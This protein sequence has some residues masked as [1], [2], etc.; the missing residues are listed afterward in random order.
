MH[1]YVR[2]GS[3]YESKRQQGLAHFLEHMLFD[4]ST[5]FKPDELV[6]YFQ[7]I[8][9]QFGADA[10]AHTGFDETVYD[11]LLPSGD[12]KGLEKGLIV[13]KDFAEGALLLPAQVEK[14]RR[15]VLSEKRTR[16]S[17]SYRTYVATINFEF[18]DAIISKRLPIGKEE[19]LKSVDRN[20]LKIF[21]D[22]WYR[23]ERMVLVL[24]GDFDVKSAEPLI[25]KTFS[26]LTPRAPPGTV[27]E[28]GS[29]NHKGVQPFYHY[30]KEAG[31]TTVSIEVIEKIPSTTDSLDFQKKRLIMNIANQIVNHR[32]DTLSRKS[33]APFTSA[34]IS[35]GI[36]LR[37]IK[38]AEISADCDPENWKPSLSLIEQTLRKALKFGFTQSELVREKK[39]FIARLDN[40]V[41]QASTRESNVLARKIIWYLNANRVFMSPGQKKELFTPMIK[42]VS[43]KDVHDAFKNIWL[44]DHRLVLVTGNVKLSDVYKD[45]KTQILDTYFKSRSVAVLKPIEKKTVMFPYLSKPKKEGRIAR[46][47]NILDLGIVQVDFKNGVRLNL[48]KTDFKADQVLVN[49]SFGQGKICE[50]LNKPGLA[51]LTAN[52]MNA[53]GL[54]TLKK[55]EIERAL[56]GKNTNVFFSVGENRFLFKGDTVSN[57]VP[58]L[59]ELLYAHVVDP[60]FRKDAYERTLKQYRQKYMAL[61]KSIDGAMAIR[62][63]RFL[64][65]G[66]PRFGLPDYKNL[67]KWT[68][69]D[70]KSWIGP[71]F[72]N[73][74]I[75]ISVVGD[76]DVDSVIKLTSEY[77]GSL[78]LRHINDQRKEV[79]NPVFPSCRSRTISVS[80]KIQKGLIVVAYPTT[81]IWNINKTRR[82][83]VL[84][85]IVSERLREQI[86]EKMGAAYSTWAFNR[87]SYAY[88]GY[89]VFQAMAYV[90]P[91]EETLLVN[92]VKKI[93]SDLIKIGITQD[94]LH[95]AVAPSLTR[96]KDM[97]RKNGYWLNTVLTGSKTHPQKLNWSRSIVKDYAS[98]SQEDILEM[99]EEYL[100]NDKAATLVIRPK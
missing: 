59:F 49:L 82:L 58:L 94:E 3:I 33:D 88:R 70:V 85:D 30:E 52:V 91:N 39:V 7:D 32:L 81:D 54:G 43:L 80:T 56:A 35:S 26:T 92:K 44:P 31:S 96:I 61:S 98:I 90:S 78:F 37:K 69:D 24:V 19:I 34:S 46:E 17:A 47:K 27:P 57:E 73:D 14:E 79:K 83:S 28:F 60:G 51:L 36:F 71:L 23:P 1:L 5:H 87:P 6:K 20:R 53:S 10:N 13:M 15:V 76:F 50:P 8:G 67:K 21:Y 12:R 4:G 45:P 62:G 97:L 65:G 66:D 89:G 38:Y 40:A 93:V 25:D 16:D 74:D 9:M 18:P 95:R 48:K 42:S 68:L 63:R 75:E 55:D 86:R 11:M 2:T 41:K 64:A 100:N 22:T 99:A 29:I 84:A 77:F 72:G